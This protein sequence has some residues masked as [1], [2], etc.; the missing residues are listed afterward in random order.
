MLHGGLT[1]RARSDRSAAAFC[2]YGC[3]SLGEADPKYRPDRRDC[4]DSEL[5]NRP[6]F[7]LD[8]FAIR[9]GVGI[10]VAGQS[11]IFG[12]A[13]N[14]EEQTSPAVKLGVQGVI[15]AGTLLVIALL[16]PP[17]FR[18]AAAELGRGRL[19][20]EALFLLTMGGAMLASLQSLISGHGPIYFEV[21]S[22]LLVVY[23][24]GK[25]I[26]A[27]SRAA[28]LATTRRWADALRFC[29]LVD[30]TGRER[31]VGVADV[32]PGDRIRVL[33]GETIPVDGV[34]REGVGFL[35]E[36]PA[37]GEPFPVVRR[38]GDRVLAGTVSYDAA[39]LIEATAA[40]S[41]RQID[42]LLQAVEEA[43]S[44]PT[45]IQ[46]QADRLGR[47][48]VPVIVATA[49][50]TFA[51]WLLISGWQAALFNAMSVLLVA[52][53]CAL[54]LATPIVLWSALSRLAER[55]FVVHSGDLI[56]RLSQIDG[57]Y[58][59]KTGTLTDDHFAIIDI[60]TFVEGADRS[61]LLGWLALIEKQSNHPIAHAFSQFNQL[62]AGDETRLIFVRVVPGCGVQAML[63]AHGETHEARIGRPEWI[64]ASAEGE[65]SL[66]SRM[67]A[68]G[69]Q[70]R[71][72][73][74]LDGRLAAI[75][76]I[77]ERLRDTVPETLA[78]LN[79]MGLAVHVLTGDTPERA[80]ALQLTNVRGNLLP[81]DKRQRMLEEIKAGKRPLMI[82]DGI[83]DAAALAVA[84]AGIA[85]SSGADLADRAATATLYHDDLR[86][87]PWA[88]DLCRNAIHTMRRNLWRAAGYNLAGITLAA[89]G[90]LHPV[91]AALLMVA[92][93]ML[94]AWSSV[95]IGAAGQRHSC[96]PS[97]SHVRLRLRAAF[98][99]AAF[100]VQGLMAILLLDL[101]LSTGAFTC[102]AFL[103]LGV[104]IAF[105]WLQWSEMPHWLDM[106]IGMLTLGN[107]GMLLG[108]WI[109]NDFM[110]LAG[111]SGCECGG[112]L[113]QGILKPWMSIGMLIFA[114]T[115]MIYFVRGLHTATSGRKISMF[116][117][118]NAGMVAG[119]L[120]GGW[121]GTNVVT[122]SITA[123]AFISFAGMTVGMVAGMLL[124]SELTYRLIGLSSKTRCLRIASRFG[125][126][127]HRE[128][129]RT[130]SVA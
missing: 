35:A 60:A 51:V 16:G 84:H 128:P 82:G 111:P 86:V 14:L 120:L 56:E 107:L 126:R 5:I 83:N 87:I 127:S 114:N 3:L 117:G 32:V 19:T 2:C 94:T 17:L 75:A 38:P 36:A 81:D 108:W 9:I 29:R 130:S 24:L 105:V 85:L 64:G 98:H 63:E 92:S 122:N 46:A 97:H 79:Q 73:F 11:M 113:A 65:S 116:A 88:I 119:M 48:F 71:I 106:T 45:T 55:G 124:G 95:H 12:L 77:A 43:R 93:S 42:R 7:Q 47:L 57:V 54:G 104:A 28:A 15:L 23:A 129:R 69:G 58:F 6:R 66:L 52:C 20:I 61:E 78:T 26:G 22:V 109:D 72:D 112:K 100:A 121:L 13:I 40:G 21:V 62:R 74:E 37:S 4:P 102:L 59:D 50:T 34:I 90:L 125:R 30:V 76:F 10:L 91:V 70:Q 99:A 39:L 53:P 27:H 110:A 18:A 41:A 89:F 67:H 31:Q 8:G 68:T 123:A 118:G 103:A 44:T 49:I 80:S 1:G 115:A 101:S 33:P 25:A 96:T